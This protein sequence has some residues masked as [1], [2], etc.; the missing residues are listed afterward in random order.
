VTVVL[1][2][3]SAVE[4]SAD[5]PRGDADR[6]LSRDQ[7]RAKASRLLRR[8]FGEAGAAVL[9]AVHGLVTGLPVTTVGQTIRSAAGGAS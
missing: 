9:Q 2:D 5:R 7:V 4:A 8:R 3:G 1:R 6:A